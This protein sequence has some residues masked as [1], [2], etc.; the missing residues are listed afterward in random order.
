[1][2]A[3]CNQRDIGERGLFIGQKHRKQV[4]GHVINSH[5]RD[6]G[7]HGQGLGKGIADQQ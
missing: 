4:A 7:D 1:M 5:I 3:G 6:A 2:P